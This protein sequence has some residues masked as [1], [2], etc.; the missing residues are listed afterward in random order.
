MKQARIERWPW[1]Y[2]K[3]SPP[4]Q[5]PPLW[6]VWDSRTG[7]LV[8]DAPTVRSAKARA[9]RLGYRPKVWLRTGD[10]GRLRVMQI[11]KWAWRRFVAGKP[12]T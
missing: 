7:Q 8:V 9:Q 4:A 3:A 10:N 5:M 2:N 11:L 6:A 1:V 12:E